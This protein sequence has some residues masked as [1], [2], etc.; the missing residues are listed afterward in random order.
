MQLISLR[1]CNFRQF[2]GK[3][4]EIFFGSGDRNATIIYGNNGAGKTTLLN[5]FTWVL[6]E[7]FTAAFTA[8]EQLVNRRAIA[9]AKAGEAVECWVELTFLHDRKRYQLKR[10]CYAI[11]RQD[12]EQSDSQLFLLYAGDDGRWLAPLQ[13]PE[14]VIN[15]ILPESLHNYFFFDGERIEHLIRADKKTEVS[16]ATKELLGIK[17]Y[18]RAIDHLK[19]ARRSLEAELEAIGDLEIKKLLRQRQQWEDKSESF[20][21][22]QQEIQ[23]ELEQQ[24]ALGRSLSQQ[25]LALS[26]VGELQQK[27]E[28]LAAEQEQKKV[29]IARARTAI[30]KVLSL[31]GY[32]FL[33]ER[34]IARFRSCIASYRQ[35]KPTAGIGQEFIRALLDHQTCLCGAPL[36]PG[37]PGH[38]N[39]CTWLADARDASIQGAIIRLE[40]QIEARE[41][42]IEPAWQEIDR[43]QVEI[44]RS[45]LEL[46]RLEREL[47]GVKDK[48][49]QYPDAD[50]QHLQQQQDTCEAKRRELL[51]EQGR[52]EQE[53]KRTARELE[54]LDRQ[55]SKQQVKEGKQALGR[56]RIDATREAIATISA[57]RDRIEHR[58]RTALEERIQEIFAAISF[59]PYQ[60]RLN[61][62]YELTLS[63]TCNGEAKIVA[64]STG[65][66]QILSL[67]FIGGIV[68]RV[69][70]WSATKTLMAPDSSTF[71][72]VMDSPFGSLDEVYRRRVAAI[73]PQIAHQLVVLVTQTQWRGEVAAEMTASVGKQYVIVYHSPKSDCEETEIT[74]GKVTYPLVRRSNAEYSEIV[75]IS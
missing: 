24:E 32:T 22:Q 11:E 38:Q 17:V 49:R 40:T 66:N 51:L 16:E 19:R 41:K 12:I 1:L 9:E 28:R 13:P 68:D 20:Q 69:R 61:E 15:A 56:R 75:E 43:N 4:P 30:A 5:S 25:L 60:P 57:V 36:I 35:S 10:L 2:Y 39:V 70:Q 67:S 14:E 7:R 48:L 34:E 47:D 44:E 52:N 29:A 26:S 58:F 73:I 71:P 62:K 72:I 37:T 65:E 53:M 31:Q 54:N 64:A 74:L 8:P 3:T 33:L 46:A 45:R 55:I 18:E 23:R 42:Q 59:T 27:K 21:Q 63:E 50:I 6:Y